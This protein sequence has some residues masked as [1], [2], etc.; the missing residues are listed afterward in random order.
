MSRNYI[1]ADKLSGMQKEV[2]D[3]ALSKGW[4]DEPIS[5]EQYLGLIVTEASEA[6]EADRNGRRAETEEFKGALTFGK[7]DGY[8]KAC[9][10]D[11]IKGSVEEEFAD[12]IIRLLDMAQG[13]F[14][15]NMDWIGSNT[16][17]EQFCPE[18]KFIETFWQF[19]KDVLGW[20]SMRIADAVAFVYAWAEH[21]GIKP[22]TLDTHICWKMRYNK[23]R[24][25]KHGGKK[26]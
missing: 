24:P 12:I 7:G 14:G 16:H 22:E 9:Y 19:V 3:I 21:L 25:Y 15:N 17:A 2:W 23:L 20:E 1:D 10:K 6:V 8:F 13:I 11:Y 5:H 4:H 18:K 26:Y